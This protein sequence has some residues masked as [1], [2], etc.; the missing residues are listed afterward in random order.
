[1]T[2]DEHAVLQLPLA[3]ITQALRRWHE[4][5]GDVRPSQ[6]LAQMAEHN[7]PLRRRAVLLL[8]IRRAGAIVIPDP[9]AGLPSTVEDARSR[10]PY[11]RGRAGPR[12][13]HDR[14]TT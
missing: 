4:Q 12:P 6:L 3:D 5:T 13:I 1:M 7:D 14:T 11:P 9:H 2:L 10:N 8:K